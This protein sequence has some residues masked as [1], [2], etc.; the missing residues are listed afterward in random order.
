MTHIFKVWKIFIPLVAL[1]TTT[2][3]QAD[4]ANLAAH[5]QLQ[6]DKFMSAFNSQDSAA[7]AKLYTTDGVF[8]GNNASP[9]RGQMEIARLMSAIFS[10]PSVQISLVTNSLDQNRGTVS[11]IGTWEMEFN[12]DNA[13]KFSQ[14]GNYVVVWEK[15]KSGEWLMAIDMVNSNVPAGQ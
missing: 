5:I 2:S 15:Q 10:G 4:D 7:L 1:I 11:E 3:A 6:N 9:V 8:I 12:P 14:T 13:E